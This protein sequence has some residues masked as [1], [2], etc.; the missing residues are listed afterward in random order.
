MLWR[1]L[2]ILAQ[3]GTKIILLP[4]FLPVI[5]IIRLISPWLICRIGIINDHIGHFAGNT[6][7][8]L[9]E[10]DAGINIPE[11]PY[12]D[13]WCHGGSNY[14][15]Q[16]DRM[17][18]RKLTIIK[19]N[20]FIPLLYEKMNL[21]SGCKSHL[22]GNNWA[23]TR[24]V[25]NLLERFPAHLSFLDEEEQQGKDGLKAVGIVDGAPFVCL[26]VRDS[27]YREKIYP[28]ENHR[29]A[30]YRDSMIGNYVPAAQALVQRGYHVIRMGAIVK[31]P[32]PTSHKMIIDYATNGMRSNFM[33]IYISANCNFFIST[34]T[35]IDAVA[36]IFRRP[37]A[38]VNLVPLENAHTWAL[39]HVFIPKKHWITTERR[40]MTFREIFKSGAGQFGATEQYVEH[41]IELIENTPEEILD[42][43]LEMESR[44]NG[45]WQNNEEDEELQR[46]FW[47]IFPRSICHYTSKPLHG[48]VRARLGANFLRQNKS[49]LD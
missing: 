10:R 36:M 41:G 47:E 13:I 45:T 31:D 37:Y 21:F 16:L 33:D 4:L 14:N 49:W 26:C 39:K 25:N 22:I 44:L 29:Q 34:G 8:Y 30:D 6:E 11:K 32:I 2:R 42:V 40:F 12:I 1:K 48:K 35:G 20:F 17:W 15:Q 46:L 23:G 5:L 28:G 38:Y 3:K 43:T 27:A 18:K 9:C 24:D 19:P 7:L